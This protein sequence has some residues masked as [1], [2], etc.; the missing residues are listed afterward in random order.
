MFEIKAFYTQVNRLE[1]MKEC[2]FW[3]KKKKKKRQEISW[4]ELNKNK[5]NTNISFN[6][7]AIIEHLCYI[8]SEQPESSM[9]IVST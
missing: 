5:S 1:R 9:L 4:H 2:L 8:E 7:F 3:K 6:C